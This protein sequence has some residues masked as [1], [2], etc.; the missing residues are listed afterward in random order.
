MINF[1]PNIL[2]A[3][4]P[5]TLIFISSSV[6]A[7]IVVSPSASRI[8]PSDHPLTSTADASVFGTVPDR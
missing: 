4:V 7:L 2:K 8:I 6:S 1:D 3:S 5:P